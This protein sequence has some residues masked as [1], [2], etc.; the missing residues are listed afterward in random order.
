MTGGGTAAPASPIGLVGLGV[1]GGAMARHLLTGGFAVVGTDIRAEACDGLT[2]AGGLAVATAAEVVAVADLVI[3]SLPSPTALH[4]VV[5][6]DCGLAAGARSGVIVVETG[7]FALADKE[8]ARGV[9]EG[10]GMVMLDAAI[11]GTGEQAQAGDVVVFLSGDPAACSRALPPL[12]ACSRGQFI[13]GD[14]GDASRMK[15]LANLLVTIHNVAAAEA[16]ALGERAGLDPAMVLEVLT[17]G[18]GNSRMLEVRGPAM[19]AAD[20]T[21]PG[22][23][24]DTFLKDVQVIGDFA[25]SLRFPVPLFDLAGSVHVSAV[26]QGHAHHDTSSVHAVVS[27]AAGVE[28]PAT[29]GGARP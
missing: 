11:S 17:A 26:A 28:R 5:S 18:A 14:F 7:T 6:G 20:Y 21:N 13:V 1:M 27:N 22:I 12:A 9:L 15:Y 24:A 29:D 8:R 3:T 23:R 2:A 16:L 25:R 10:A 4:E 19:V